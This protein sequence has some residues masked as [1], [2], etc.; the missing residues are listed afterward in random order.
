MSS[1]HSTVFSLVFL[2]LCG[3]MSGCFGQDDSG[4]PSADSLEISGPFTAGDWTKVTLSASSDLSV[5]IPYFVLDPG[6][7]RAQNGTVL[8]LESGGS[9]DVEWLLPPRNLN[10]I[11]LIGE[12]GRDDW[13]V[14]AANESWQDW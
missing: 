6:S 3:P 14:R 7:L 12:F 10:A 5:Y 1:R 4:L 9:V 11:L 8:D 2:L 13:P